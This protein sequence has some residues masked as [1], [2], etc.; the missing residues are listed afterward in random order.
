MLDLAIQDFKTFINMFKDV[1]ENIISE[2]IG[3]LRREIKAIKI[4]KNSRTEKRS[5]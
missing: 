2:Q 4:K 1:K 3:N 5:A